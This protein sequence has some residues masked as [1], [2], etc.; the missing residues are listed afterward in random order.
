MERQSLFSKQLNYLF[1]FDLDLGAARADARKGAPADSAAVMTSSANRADPNPK[2]NVYHALGA[3]NVLGYD[4]LSGTVEFVQDTIRYLPRNN[5]AE[6]F[7][8]LVIRSDDNQLIQG[9]YAGM[10][11]SGRG[12]LAV[13]SSYGSRGQQSAREPAVDAK[14]HVRVRFETGST[15]Y[16]WLVGHQCVGY[17]TLELCRGEPARGTF[18]IYALT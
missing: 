16:Q 1:S 7:G 3:S 15:K 5:F 6:I 2:T 14:A 18:D 13:R 11:R 4:A 8:R 10:A 12:W 9:E 17:G